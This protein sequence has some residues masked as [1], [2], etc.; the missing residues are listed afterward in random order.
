MVCIPRLPRSTVTSRQSKS[1]HQYNAKEY[2]WN[3]DL[4]EVHHVLQKKGHFEW[5]SN[6]TPTMAKDRGIYWLFEPNLKSLTHHAEQNSLASSTQTVV[7][8]GI[9]NPLIAE[10]LLKNSKGSDPTYSH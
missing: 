10:D 9:P 8:K 4:L 2:L 3:K 1:F 5:Y 7:G 6:P